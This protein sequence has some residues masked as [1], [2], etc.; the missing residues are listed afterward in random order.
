MTK[1]FATIEQALE[2]IRQGKMLILVD[3][4]SRENEGDLFIPAE[5]VTPEAINFMATYGRGVVCLP[6]SEHL[7][8]K[9]HLPLINKNLES[10]LRPAFTVSIEAATGVSTGVSAHDRAH[11]I[12]VA[13]NPQTTAN[14]IITPGH[15][16][17]LRA[18]NNGVLTRP[19]HTEASVDLARLA[20]FTAAGVICEIM[21]DDGH[22][23]RLA[24][25]QQFAVRHDLNIVSI[26]DIIAY[27]MKHECHVHEAVTAHLPLNHH[28]DFTLKVFI[29]D[30]DGK[31]HLVLIKG[32]LS[33]KENV[34]V[35]VHSECFT[36]DVLNSSRCDCGWQLATSIEKIAQE[37][38]V[39]LYLRQEGR[40]IGLVNKIK[41]YALQ[42]NGLDTVEANQQ[43]GFSADTRDYGVAAQILRSLDITKIRLLTNNPTKIEHLNNYGINVVKREP[44]QMQPTDNNSAYLQIKQSKLGHLLNII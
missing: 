30:V 5:K 3:D 44:L 32:D 28:G 25:L 20:G 18:R 13:I 11:T 6:M 34:L 31:E 26:N 38:G 17:P 2:D 37:G 7:I 41:A 23:A 19:G 24:D 14:D 21:N 33:K 42:D 16:F 10:K 43:L 9:L 39:L 8:D 12:Q 4:A 22:M 15:V 27:R 36:G 29:D 35:R 40:G 1:P